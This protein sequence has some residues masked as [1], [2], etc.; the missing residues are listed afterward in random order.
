MW[1]PCSSLDVSDVCGASSLFK[2][3]STT[4]FLFF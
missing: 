4:G 2:E 3:G 1:R